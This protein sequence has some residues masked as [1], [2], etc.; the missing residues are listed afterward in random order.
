MINITIENWIKEILSI[1][2]PQLGVKSQVGD[3]S[4][5][6][7][8]GEMQCVSYFYCGDKTTTGRW[9][10]MWL[11]MSTSWWSWRQH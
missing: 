3:L 9:A 6:R 4:A 5:G 2:G 11:D 7:E 8:R 10:D 1:P